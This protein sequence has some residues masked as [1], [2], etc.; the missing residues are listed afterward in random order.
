[1]KRTIGT[2]A[3]TALAAIAM[4]A[5]TACGE[6]VRETVEINDGKYVLAISD[7]MGSGEEA[8]NSSLH[9]LRL[10]ENLLLSGF[11]KNISLEQPIMYIAKILSFFNLIR[12]IRVLY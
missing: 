12:H 7:G 3:R 11:D 1:M 9:A 2:I 5:G 6:A 8:K 4:Q 10:L